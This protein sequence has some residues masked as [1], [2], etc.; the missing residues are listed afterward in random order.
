M[1]DKTIIALSRCVCGTALLI[2]HALTGVNGSLIA[3]SLFLLGVPV[4]LVKIAKKEKEEE[5]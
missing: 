3:V 4:E 5:G 1:E 2:T